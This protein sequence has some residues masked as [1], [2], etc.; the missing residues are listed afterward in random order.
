MGNSRSAPAPE[1]WVQMDPVP[2]SKN[3]GP[4]PASNPSALNPSAPAFEPLP[5]MTWA[6]KARQLA[7]EAATRQV[8]V[9]LDDIDTDDNDDYVNGLNAQERE[10]PWD[11]Q[12]YLRSIRG[13]DSD[14]DSDPD[15]DYYRELARLHEYWMKEEDVGD[16]PD[17]PYGDDIP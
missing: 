6:Q 7:E 17:A 3:I 14:T 11:R 13:V 16:V 1:D 15:S 8:V 9:D 12:A 5:R 10:L 2:E 4:N